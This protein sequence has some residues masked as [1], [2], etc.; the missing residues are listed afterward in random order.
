[1]YAYVSLYEWL[2]VFVCMFT[3]A[4]MYARCVQVLKNEL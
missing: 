3:I 4:R 2:C 1:M